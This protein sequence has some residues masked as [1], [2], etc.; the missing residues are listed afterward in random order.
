MRRRF[1]ITAI[2]ALFFS[3]APA[4]HA[5]G[6]DIG[7]YAGEFLRT[8]GG[9][10]ALGMGGAYV[11]VANDASSVYW[12]PAALS[13]VSG[14][15]ILFLHSSR[16]SGI[17]KYNFLAFAMPWGKDGGIGVGMIRL[18]VDNIPRTALTNPNLE[19][20]EVYVD[21][22]GKTRINK[23]YVAYQF[24]DAE[25]GFFLAFG[26][27]RN[28]RLRFG[29]AVKV[30]HKAFDQNTAWGL[31]F[32]FS[33]RYQVHDRL[34]LGANFQD[35]TTTLLVWD[36][37][38]KELIVPTLKLGAMLPLDLPAVQLRVLPALDADVKFE[39]LGKAAQVDLGRMSMDFHA[40][41]ELNYRERMAIRLG[42]DVG[43]FT[44]GAGLRLPRLS[45]DY[46]FMSH[47][48][49]G[50]THRISLMVSLQRSQPH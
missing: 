4:L 2:A 39:R 41:V 30:V 48:E 50:D 25:Y 7:K 43:A 42:S 46:A 36:T 31:G 10:R 8:G 14:P 35:L 24:S 27:Q 28:E 23:P 40:G 20:G 29:G 47:N 37:G 12:N 22:D 13:L 34:I 44:A 5:Q 45:V 17:I 16:F 21:E 6:F 11:A 1:A 32:D 15:Q 19:L 49:L 18:G 26:K 38:R 9:A 3:T 33:A